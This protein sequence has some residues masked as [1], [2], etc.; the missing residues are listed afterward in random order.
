MSGYM[1]GKAGRDER[2]SFA[3]VLSLRRAGALWE[4][5]DPIVPG[6]SDFCF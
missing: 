4:D 3:G 1:E 6:S 5:G 2:R